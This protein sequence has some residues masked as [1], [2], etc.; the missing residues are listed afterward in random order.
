MLL[1]AKLAPTF[2]YPV[3]ED[4]WR[5]A[6]DVGFHAIWN[7]DHLYG[8]TEPSMPTLEAWTTLSAM[9]AVTR[10][11]RVG[12]MVTD[13]TYRHPALL[14]KMAVT[15]DQISQGRLSFGI[16]TGWH[17]AEHRDNGI[18]FP[19]PGTRVAMLDEAL[20]VIRRLWSEDSVDIAG[21]FFTLNGARCDPKPIQRPNPPIIVGG[22]KPKM[23]RVVA[24]HAD[25]WNWTGTPQEW[26]K[27]NE[28]LNDVCRDIGRN[29]SEIGRSVQLFLHPQDDGQV[30][31]QLAA[32]PEYEK[33]GCQHA[34]LSFYQPPTGEL[35]RRCVSLA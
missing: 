7:Y 9:A 31:E 3:L 23:L 25:E 4:F 22:G 8:L 33:L 29:P 5:S 32:I 2:G 19:S 21:R 15:V 18:A 12:C 10:H 27:A 13:V 17:D 24:R 1:S 35:L 28:R 30:E 11:A 26:G 20:T 34:V 14:A 6:D 16:G